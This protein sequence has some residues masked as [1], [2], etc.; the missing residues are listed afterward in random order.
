MNDCCKAPAYPFH[1]T[2]AKI[3]WHYSQD[4]LSRAYLFS[5]RPENNTAQ[6]LT[7]EASV[8]KGSIIPIGLGLVF[9]INQRHLTPTN[10][11]ISFV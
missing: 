1:A 5:F 4:H 10:V 3:G 9:C 11:I 7:D 6:W 2:V 8:S